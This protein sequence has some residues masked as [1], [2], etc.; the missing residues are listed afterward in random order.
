MPVMDEFREE[1][2]SIKQG[3]FKQKYQYF[4]D[5]YRTPLIITVLAASFILLLLFKFVT[6]KETAFYAAMLNCSPYDNTE[7]AFIQ[8]YA[9]AAG[10]DLAKSKI[11]FDT[12]MYYKLDQV[13]E[14][15]YLTSQKLETFAGAGL[16][17]VMLGTGE[18]F[19]H[20]A[21]GIFFKDLREVL[22][23][24]QLEAYAPYLYYVDG[25]L[26]QEAIDAQS[27]AGTG[28]PEPIVP[29]DPR[30]PEDMR[31]PIPIAIYVESS[32]TLQS[33]YYFKDA[34]KGIALGIYINSPHID[35]DIAF[36]E[37]LLQ[38]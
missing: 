33:T 29:L 37:Y 34:D 9:D 17:N 11:T 35:Y 1:R 22:T 27:A 23:T 25:A 13:D 26:I 15:S 19:A 18:E 5:Y 3:T 21:N 4:K 38:H 6:N 14:T 32:E 7:Q 30:H 20:F 12:V 31:D 10:I 36:I 2:E 28:E 16:L 24:A 8:E